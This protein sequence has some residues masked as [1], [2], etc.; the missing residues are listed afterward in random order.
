MHLIGC[1]LAQQAAAADPLNCSP[2][3]PLTVC[4]LPSVLGFTIF[5]ILVLAFVEVPSSFT[6]TAD[7]RYRSQPWQP[8]CGLT[9]TIE[10]LCLLVFLVDLS[11]KVRCVVHRC[12]PQSSWCR[13]DARAFVVWL[14]VSFGTLNKSVCVCVLSLFISVCVSALV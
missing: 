10:A 8:P 6:K 4:L 3:H 11:V 13:L 5:L 1:F 14:L 12:Y 2:A 7:V 9:E